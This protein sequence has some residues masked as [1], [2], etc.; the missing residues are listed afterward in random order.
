MARSQYEKGGREWFKRPVGSWEHS[1]P[2]LSIVQY[3]C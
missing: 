1:T 3:F 2:E